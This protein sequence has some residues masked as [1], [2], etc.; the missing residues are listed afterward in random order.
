MGR[1]PFP[2]RDRNTSSVTLV[3]KNALSVRRVRF[4]IDVYSSARLVVRDDDEEERTGKGGPE[5]REDEELL[6]VLL[7]KKM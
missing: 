4:G 3:R 2:H 6:A 7:I 1:G 5:R